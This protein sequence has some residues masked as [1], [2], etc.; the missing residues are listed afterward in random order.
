MRPTS[1]QA[2]HALSVR[3]GGALIPIRRSQPLAAVAALAAAAAAACGASG[4]DSS[5]KDP[6]VAFTRNLNLPSQAVWAGGVAGGAR[7]IASGRSPSV[8]PD[9]RTV[10]YLG[11]CRKSQPWECT[12]L[13]VV[14]SSGG[15]TRT[16]LRGAGGPIV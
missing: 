16:L 15:Q 3:A 7:R 8:A 1:R 2:P 9:G 4:S 13:A 10:A 5:T 12:H 6:I 11:G 14:S